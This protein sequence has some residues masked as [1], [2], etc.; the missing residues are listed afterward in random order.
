MATSVMMIVMNNVMLNHGGST[1][2]AGMNVV[3]AVQTFIMPP[4][5]GISLE[6]SQL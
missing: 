3:N 6:S 4:I 2:I 5:W 1:A